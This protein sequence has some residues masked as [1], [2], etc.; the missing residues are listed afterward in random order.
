MEPH[1]ILHLVSTGLT[2]ILIIVYSV[3]IIYQKSLIRAQEGH[4]K[5]QNLFNDT[6][7]RY[8]FT[9]IKYDALKEENQDYETAKKCQ[10]MLDQLDNRG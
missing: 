1:A 8:C 9:K 6:L 2:S 10:D 7:T 3:A 5:R 4:I